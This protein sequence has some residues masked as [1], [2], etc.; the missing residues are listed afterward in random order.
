M[1]DEYD[2]YI[3]NKLNS[4]SFSHVDE[5]L[6]LFIVSRFL[7]N[8]FIQNLLAGANVL[9]Y[10]QQE[11]DSRR[12][13]KID[14]DYAQLISI[15]SE[16]GVAAFQS[17]NYPNNP[18]P[19]KQNPIYFQCTGGYLGIFYSSDTQS[20]DFI[21]PKRTII[22]PTASIN[23]QSCAFSNF[24]VYSQVVPLS[25]WEIKN[26]TSIFGNE[27]NNWTYD[28]I[29]KSKYQSL[30]RLDVNSRYFRN[31]G[32]SVIDDKGY[33][34]AVDGAGDLSSSVSNW[35]KNNPEPQLVTVGAPFHFYFGL[36]RGKSAYDRFRS[37]WVNTEIT[38][39]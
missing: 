25:Q 11:D 35:T 20:R 33:I 2:G 37:K 31:N 38:T 22:N 8:G 39:T 29:Y 21:T 12:N 15:N 3:A 16:F 13:Y 17:S 5:I 26:D 14:A 27:G 24:P 6:N 4:S 10:F 34:Y 23:N 9:A 18:D 7:D 30:D 28:P 32:I 36:K 1:S 19:M